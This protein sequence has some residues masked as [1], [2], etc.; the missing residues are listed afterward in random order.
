MHFKS[1]Y[2]IIVP[3]WITMEFNNEQATAYFEYEKNRKLGIKS[4]LYY[5]SI[6]YILIYI[7]QIFLIILAPMITKY[8]LYLE[9]ANSEL[10]IH[11]ENETFISAWTQFIIYL[12][13]FI[14][15]VFFNIRNLINDLK[16][17]KTEFKK[18]FTNIL[19]GIGVFF[20]AMIASALFLGIFN[21]TSSSDNQEQIE[22]IMTGYYPI[23]LVPALV[24]LG[25]V[26][27]ELI[28]RRSFFNIFKME[29][30]KWI[31]II[32]SGSVFG[33]IHVGM[34]VLL[35]IIEKAPSQIIIEELL[36]GVPYIL[37]GIGLSYIYSRSEENILPVLIIHILN[38][39]LSCIMV[40]G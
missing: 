12:I 32:V 28:F 8:P 37:Q 16:D 33:F 21:I 27:E 31:K 9:N 3:R 34:A 20:L 17:F 38:N 7:I 25:P 19:I 5:A 14:G 22:K 11:P 18:H 30:K 39:L 40:L 24:I 23:I 29:T 13:I 4:I 6:M 26:C 1:F 35:Y 36:L 15:L 2:D 10:I